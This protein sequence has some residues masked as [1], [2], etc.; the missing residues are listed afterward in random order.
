MRQE[1]RVERVALGRIWIRKISD[2][3]TGKHG[4]GLAEVLRLL[5]R[6]SRTAVVQFRNIP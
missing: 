4:A 1:N 3:Y 6:G 5:L 2:V